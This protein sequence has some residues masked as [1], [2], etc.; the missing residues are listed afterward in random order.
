MIFISSG[1]FLLGCGLFFC[2]SGSAH[3]YVH[4]AATKSNNCAITFPRTPCAHKICFLIMLCILLP[5]K[6]GV[7][8]P[9]ML[10]T[11]VCADLA[12]ED[13]VYVNPSAAGG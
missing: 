10:N 3:V 2:G 1:R 13:T 6:L 4:T 7:D 9:V 11:S 5:H 12:I 8:P